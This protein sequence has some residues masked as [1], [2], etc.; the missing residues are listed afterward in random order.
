M[1]SLLINPVAFSIGTLSVH[2]YGLILGLGAL[3]GLLL[4]IQEGKR[5]S[6]PQEFFMDLL[7]LGVPSAIIGARI[8]YVAFKWEDYQDNFLDVFKIWEGGIAIFGALIGAIICA[9]IYVRRK[10]YNFWRIA[11]ICAP[12]LLA[13]QIIGRW[14]NFVN[15]EAYGGPV[16]ESFLRETLRLPDFIVNQMNVQGVFHHPTFLYESLWNVV[17]IIL[18]FII[19]RQKFLRAGELFIGYF[20][21]YSIGRFFIEAVRTD[22]L[23]FR[24]AS[25]LAD[26]VNGLWSPMTWMGFEQGFLD[27]AYG[28]VRISQLLSILFVV[29]GIALII[30]RRV[31]GRA[32]ERYLDPI[33]STKADTSTAPTPEAELRKGE[34]APSKPQ[35]TTAAAEPNEVRERTNINQPPAQRTEA[36][37]E[38]T[39]DV[40][41]SLDSE[42][43]KE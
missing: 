9:V 3:A 4:A 13:G 7:L 37:R 39:P 25:G 6:I 15:Q 34:A 5:F 41:E 26:F 23:A 11:D 14:G 31:T 22:S 2:W 24:G 12:S 29:V 18:I 20:I 27:P 38:D 40:S 10:G 1:S 16:E 17:G 30:F 21:W 33:V 35:Q 43:K 36:G 8:Y 32:N 28:N 19:R 42:D